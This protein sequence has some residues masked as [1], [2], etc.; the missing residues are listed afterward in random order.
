MPDRHFTSRT[1]EFTLDNREKARRSLTT[2]QGMHWWANWPVPNHRSP[3]FDVADV[4]WL[5][6][7][8]DHLLAEK[9]STF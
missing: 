4:E 8:I 5:F 1:Q 9:E 6:D 3:C 2:A 7:Y